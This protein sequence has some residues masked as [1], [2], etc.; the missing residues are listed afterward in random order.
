MRRTLL[1]LAALLILQF[2]ALAVV[3]SKTADDESTNAPTSAQITIDNFSFGP[4]TLTVAVGTTVT[5][6]NH[7]DIPHN[8]VS[9]EKVFKSKVLDTNESYSFTFTKAGVFPYFCSIHPKMTG[10]VVVK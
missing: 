8:I 4:E 10:K 3:S 5:W 7:D 6:T 2:T 1:I 9:T